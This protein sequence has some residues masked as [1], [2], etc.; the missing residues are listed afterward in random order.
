MSVFNQ[1][2]NCTFFDYCILDEASLITE[3]LSIGPLMM[4]NRFIMIGDYYLLN[5]MVKN[6]DA[7]KLGMSISLFR[8]LTE[9]HRSDAVILKS[10]YRMNDNICFLINKIAYVKLIK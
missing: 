10:Q 1:F 2:F 7:E 5:P 4:A 8:K 9:Q 6:P 3:P